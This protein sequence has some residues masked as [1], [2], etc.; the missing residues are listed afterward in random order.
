MTLRKAGLPYLPLILA[1][2]ILFAPAIFTGKAI[3]WG[4]PVLQFV[5]WRYW[6][7]EALI[8]GHLP[9]WNPEVGMGAP[10]VANYQSALFY[11]FNWVYFVLAAVGGVPA[12]A[13]GQ[14][15][16]VALHLAWA[17]I[18]MALLARRLGLNALA[19]TISGLAFGLSGYLVGRAGF[20]SINA[21]V[22][23][24]PWILIACWQ[25]S[26]FPRRTVTIL[27]L[28]ILAGLQLLA[29]HA[30]VAWYTLLLAYLWSGWLAW[31]RQE[32][33][34]LNGPADPAP[35]AGGVPASLNLWQHT[36]GRIRRVAG[37]WG[38]LSFAWL[39]AVLLAAVQIFPTAE[40]LMQSHRASGVDFEFA[41]TYSFWPWRLLGLLAPS[42]FGNPANGDYWGYA[43]FWE[44]AIY[45][46]VIPL[47]LA[48]AAILAGASSWIRRKKNRARQASGLQPV[49]LGGPPRQGRL[50][51]FLSGVILLS[52]ALAL[53][54]NTPL[55]PTLYN[56]VPSFGL[57][58]APT[59]FTLW[60]EFALA[61]LAGVGAHHWRRP[62]GRGLYWAR[63][64]TAA[65]VAVALGA[66]LGWLL[67]GEISPSFI[68]A[69]AMAG[70]WAVAAGLLT[71][72]APR[73]P[74]GPREPA[75]PRSSRSTGWAWAVAAVL[76][77]D[78]VVAGWGLNPAI[79]LDLYRRITSISQVL[80]AGV[81]DGRIYISAE[82]ERALKF[83]RFFRF[84]TF[85][86]EE[87]WRN[88]P[89]SLLPNLGM[90]AGVQSAN[91]FDPLVSGRYAAW[92][93]ALEQAG[94]QTSA[95]M[96][97]LMAVNIVESID[98]S[99]PHG[100]NYTYRRNLT[101]IRWLPCAKPVSGGEEALEV[102]LQ[103]DLDIERLVLLEGAP[104]SLDPAC[105]GEG[106]GSVKIISE[107]PNQVILAAQAS[108]P[109]YVVMADVFYPGWEAW[110]NGERVPLLRANYLFRAVSV[111]AGEHEIRITYR[112]AWFYTGLVSSLFAW[113]G[114]VLYFGISRRAGQ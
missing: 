101:R 90:L 58:N 79:E 24:L 52:F 18:G 85:Y 99:Q 29:G 107:N 45:I 51:L 88:L 64:G 27:F 25:I 80:P 47:L 73:L 36:A 10:L 93:S 28:A 31:F 87:D 1:P 82:D 98:E 95:R 3:F 15:A 67:L 23:W 53:G 42:L 30:Q 71:L 33:S 110:L 41:M 69:T 48:C 100:I 106:K 12:L 34:S 103:G 70:V 8:S 84:D 20:L 104:A 78:L 65:G 11:P 102:V 2:I 105:R 59:R 35:G 39:L 16:L 72:A 81:E 17:G 49:A 46:G 114:V 9:L 40:Y 61:L 43:N 7:W 6:A 63:L 92:M 83:E 60:A 19:Q 56:H 97:N 113:T 94:P 91:N 54:E 68:R 21:T 26:M 77:A 37:V 74:M 14:A 76:S 75:E 22:A 109:G 62:G 96:L 4:T 66:G 57:F 13:W 111:P 89:A 108:A 86:P 5:P 38:L 44:D 50:V 55:F 32:G 112:P